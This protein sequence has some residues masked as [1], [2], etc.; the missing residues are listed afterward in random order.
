MR[1]NR[2]T[3]AATILLALIVIAL[4]MTACAKDVTVTVDD[5]GAKTELNTKTG[6]KVSEALES[7]GITLGDKDE[8]DPAADS[9][10][11]EDTATITVKRYAEITIIK[12]GKEQKAAVTGGTVA[13]ALTKAGINLADDESADVEL[14]AYVKNGMTVN[15]LKSLTV[16]LTADGKITEVTTKAATV[17]A[18][19]AEQKITL[20]ADD[21]V[22]EKLDAKLSAGMKIVVKRVVYKEETA[23]ESIDYDNQEEYS[24]EMPEGES[25]VTQT[26][27]KGEKTV[28][29]KVKYV[30]GKEAGREKISEKITKEPVDQIITYGSG[31]SSDGGNDSGDGGKEIVSKTDYP[32]CWGDG[33]GYYE[34]LYSDG[35]TEVVE[36]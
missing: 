17:E 31:Q 6:T 30:D 19:L 35:T 22:S 25:K 11:A 27:V 9:E 36:Y 15:I 26:G 3:K 7:A 23:T 34:I 18:L 13:D 10:I 8:A 29:Y 2:I 24:D 16:S 5:M 32:N 14:T 12:D 1:T 33:H 4:A 21:E 28:T 20:S